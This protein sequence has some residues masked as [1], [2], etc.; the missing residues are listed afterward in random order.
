MDD[1]EN[2]EFE[3]N[4]SRLLV[5]LQAERDYLP[6]DALSL[7]DWFEDWFEAKN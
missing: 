3:S 1:D 5:L 2:E 7:I 6:E 4:L